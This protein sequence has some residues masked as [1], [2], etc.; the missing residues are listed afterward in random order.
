[1]KT[2]WVMV[3]QRTKDRDDDQ[4]GRDEEVGRDLPDDDVSSSTNLPR[5]TRLVSRA[6][7]SS[8]RQVLELAA[9]ERSAFVARVVGAVPTFGS[10]I[11][12]R[13]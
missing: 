4:V 8:L 1:L 3:P 2:S 11:R 12:P 9:R 10:A 6:D 13:S 7:T 5:A